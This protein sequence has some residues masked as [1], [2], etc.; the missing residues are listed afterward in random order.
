MKSSVFDRTSLKTDREKYSGSFQQK[1]KVADC[2]GS[3]DLESDA[4]LGL[5][6]VRSRS[7]F[8]S[9]YTWA[10]H[11][12]IKRTISACWL[13]FLPRRACAFPRRR[14]PLP[15]KIATWR[16]R[17]RPTEN[18]KSNRTSLRPSRFFA[19]RAHAYP[20]TAVRNYR[21]YRSERLGNVREVFGAR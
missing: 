3:W 16:E 18:A 12:K 1:K 21:K 14:S 13:K 6:T 7:E 2:T 17:V 5:R 20:L 4:I 9:N 8:S 15:E 10:R 11:E 19:P